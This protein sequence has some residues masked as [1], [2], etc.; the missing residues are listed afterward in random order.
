MSE[1]AIQGTSLFLSAK[2]SARALCTCVDQG[3]RRKLG[4]QGQGL[5]FHPAALTAVSVHLNSYYLTFK[6]P[7]AF[8]KDRSVTRLSFEL[9]SDHQ[10][11]SYLEEH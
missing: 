2:L 7:F 9:K 5:V 4:G 3:E 8:Q 10:I 6:I 11:T 1:H